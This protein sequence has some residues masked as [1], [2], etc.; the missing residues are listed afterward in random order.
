METDVAELTKAAY[1][2]KQTE[3]WT[4]DRYLNRHPE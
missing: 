4:Q 3:R 1:R 2:N